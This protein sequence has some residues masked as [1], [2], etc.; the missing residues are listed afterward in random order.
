MIS[1]QRLAAHKGESDDVVGA[2]KASEAQNA[3]EPLSDDDET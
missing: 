1:G 3:A 2:M